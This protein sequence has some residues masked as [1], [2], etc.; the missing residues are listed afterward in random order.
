MASVTVQVLGKTKRIWCDKGIVY[1]IPAYGSRVCGLRKR[2]EKAR[3]QQGD[4]RLLGPPLGRG[5]DG[6]ARTRDRKVPADLRADLQATVPP[7]PLARRIP[8]TVLR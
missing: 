3:P 7:T 5:A 6:G 2:A 1:R 8:K 4:L